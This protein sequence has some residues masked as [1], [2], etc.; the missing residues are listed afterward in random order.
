MSAGRAN[1]VGAPVRTPS[2]RTPVTADGEQ[3]EPEQAQVHQPRQRAG[4]PCRR[5]SATMP[6]VT[7]EA[8]ARITTAI[9][10]SVPTCTTMSNRIISGDSGAGSVEP[11]PASP[12]WASARWLVELTGTNMNTPWTR[13]SR[14][15]S[16]VD[17]DASVA[18]AHRRLTDDRRRRGRRPTSEPLSGREEVRNGGDVEAEALASLG[19]ERVRSLLGMLS[20]DQRA[21]LALRIIG[22][23]TVEQ[24]AEAIGKRPGAVKALQRRAL[25]ALRKVLAE[26]EAAL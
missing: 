12:C 22:D 8:V 24:V 9:D 23:L 16:R 2:P 3:A 4:L 5:R 10:T 7:A 17:M 1:A 14:A 11:L 25:A 21:V 18:L 15:A 13:P 6:P 26:Q 19:D 20:P